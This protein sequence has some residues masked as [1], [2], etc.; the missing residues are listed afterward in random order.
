MLFQR[1]TEHFLNNE[2]SQMGLFTMFRELWV[3]KVDSKSRLPMSELSGYHCIF[4]THLVTDVNSYF[5]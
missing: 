5:L 1:K 4:T 2:F 3:F